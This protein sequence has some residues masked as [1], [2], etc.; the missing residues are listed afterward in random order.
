M[1]L[2][3]A[4]RYY[5]RYRQRV[6][7]E[8][9]YADSLLAWAYNTRCGRWIL[10]LVLKQPCFS[11]L[12][13]WY[14][15]QPMSR[16]MIRPFVKKMHVDTTEITRPL[17]SYGSFHA[18]FTREIDLG[19][20]PVHPEGRVCIAPTDGKVLAYSHVRAGTTFRVKRSAFNLESF[21]ADSGLARD[22]NGGSMM[23]GRL[24]FREY[25]HFHFPDSGVPGAAVSI[26]GFLHAGGPY[27]E[28]GLVPFYAENH[29][30]RTPFEADHF[31][32]MLL[33][34]IGAMAVGSI[35]QLYRPGT[36]VGKGERKGF[37]APGGSTVVL[38]FKKG[39]IDFD[40]D[41]LANT[42]RG[43]ET[44]IRMGDSIGRQGRCK[45]VP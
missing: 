16:R 21:L 39:V 29:R 35:H 45:D 5:D 34:E 4:I 1:K 27:A 11:R 24:C 23:I 41:L 10:A 12:Y 17:A 33:V 8:Q 7:Q 15:R 31:G 13:G 36:R 38:L 20:R 40:E 2:L 30:V 25:H 37:F 32:P 18:F 22:Y 26:P 9:V 42:E 44:S 43:L 3:P 19:K 6:E 14:C 28:H